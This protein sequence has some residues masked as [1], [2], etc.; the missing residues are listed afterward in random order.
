MIK[1]LE[2]QSL[3]FSLLLTTQ[4]KVL[5]A[6]Q[7]LLVFGLARSAL[8]A[9]GNLLGG[10]GLLVEDGLGLTTITRLLAVVA[11][12]ALDVEGRLAGLVLGDLLGGVLLALFTESV[13]RLG[14]AH[15][16][17]VCVWL[18]GLLNSMDRVKDL[19]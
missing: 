2:S 5:A 3:T 4:L 12:L 19:G 16:Q 14:N 13:A 9:Q 8:H 1:P 18:V 7:H 11:A 17:N 15:L 10:L 6:L